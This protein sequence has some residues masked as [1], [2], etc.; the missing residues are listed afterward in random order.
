MKHSPGWGTQLR[1]PSCPSA[2]P[3]GVGV[4]RAV[5]P[6]W[7]RR[8]RVFCRQRRA[9]LSEPQTS[10]RTERSVLIAL[11]PLQR[12]RA[13][14][15]AQPVKTPP[16]M[17]ET[18]VQSLDRE[19]PPGEGR[20]YPLQ[21]SGLENSMDCEAQGVARSRTQLSDFHFTHHCR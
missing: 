17:R 15:A 13:A 7:R 19:D 9:G 20:G 16:A 21:C 18:W 12:S 1:R 6:L 14:L 11:C 2:L 3:P 4:P 5:H 8:C 10:H